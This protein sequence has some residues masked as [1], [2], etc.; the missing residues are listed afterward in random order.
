MK[1]FHLAVAGLL[2]A[3]TPALAGPPYATF[4]VSSE[5]TSAQAVI[6]A[7][8]SRAAAVRALRKVPSVGV[9]NLNIRRTP[10]MRDSS[11]PEAYEFRGSARRNAAGIAKLR[12][13]LKANPVTRR[14]LADHDIPVNRVVGVRI[15]SNGS[16]RLYIL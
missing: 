15:G 14:A 4:V 8:G 1:P 16:L 10:F 13:A 3:T 6:M 11:L 7:A 12:A 9:I 2:L 5:L